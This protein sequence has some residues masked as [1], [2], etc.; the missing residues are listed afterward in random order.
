MNSTLSLAAIVLAASLI[1][2]P[3]PA[4]PSVSLVDWEGI[5]TLTV[6]HDDLNLATPAGVRTLNRRIAVAVDRVCALPNAKHIAQ[7]MR[8]EDCHNIALRQG[9]AQAGRVIGAAQMSARAN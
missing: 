3:A 1:A 7:R 8:I 5:R 6:E 9:L 2:S 4:A